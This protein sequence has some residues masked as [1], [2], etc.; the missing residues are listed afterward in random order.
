VI[1]ACCTIS[2][3]AKSVIQNEL[4][5]LGNFASN[6]SLKHHRLGFMTTNQHLSKPRDY[7]TQLACNAP[8]RLESGYRETC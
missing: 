4:E 5:G 1:N 3:M 7:N 2:L 6:C 8:H